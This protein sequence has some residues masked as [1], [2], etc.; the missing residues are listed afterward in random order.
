MK[1]MPVIISFPVSSLFAI[2]LVK[3]ELYKNIYQQSI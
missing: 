3:S 1:A 2:S